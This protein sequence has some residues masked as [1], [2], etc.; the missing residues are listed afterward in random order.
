MGPSAPDAEG[1]A[2]RLA[3]EDGEEIKRRVLGKFYKRKTRPRQLLQPMKVQ[4]S[5]HHVLPFTTLQC[6]ELRQTEEFHLPPIRQSHHHG[7]SSNHDS[8]AAGSPSRPKVLT[9]VDVLPEI[10][11]REATSGAKPSAGWPLHQAPLPTAHASR[12]LR[13]NGMPAM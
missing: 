1:C 12:A 8:D 13:R 2:A 9:L 7:N 6:S 10:A 4:Q 5:G 11:H 3:E